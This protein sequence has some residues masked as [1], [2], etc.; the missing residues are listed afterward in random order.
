MFVPFT[1]L[2]RKFKLVCAV[3][4]VDEEPEGHAAYDKLWSDHLHKDFSLGDL[5]AWPEVVP[6]SGRLDQKLKS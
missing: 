3:T 5:R 1:L 2:V 6:V 4:L